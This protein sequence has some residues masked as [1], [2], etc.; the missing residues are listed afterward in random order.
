MT[1]F[2]GL[3][4]W[5]KAG[6]SLRRSVIVI[7]LLLFITTLDSCHC[8]FACGKWA[9][10]KALGTGRSKELKRMTALKKGH[11]AG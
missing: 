7:V 8:V 6:A 2:N 5:A 9:A 11:K 1:R 3:D 4:N 10:L